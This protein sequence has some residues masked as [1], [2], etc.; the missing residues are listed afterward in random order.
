MNY[1]RTDSRNIGSLYGALHCISQQTGSNT[2][3]LPVEINR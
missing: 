2:F 1:K 3:S